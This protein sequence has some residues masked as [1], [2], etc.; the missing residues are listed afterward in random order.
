MERSTLV[1]PRIARRP[2]VRAR[3]AA[4]PVGVPHSTQ[5]TPMLTRLAHL[6]VRHRR[7]VI[8]AWLALTLVGVFAAGKVSTRWY[9]SFA[10]PGKPAY[11]ASQ[12]TLKAFGAGARSPSTV[13]F[14]TSGD[15]TRST[16]VEAA[17]Q[18]AA[19][20]MPGA[21]ATS[22]F[23]TGDLMYVSRDRHTA[24]MNVYPPG[25]TRLDLKSGAEQMRAAAARGLPPGIAVDVTGHDPLEEATS[26]GSSGGSVLLEA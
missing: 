25:P 6:T 3:A 14:H 18:R 5:E 9:Q 24:F 15:A 8:G 22:Y 12:R 17:M 11:E 16:A 1:G 19:D 26:H 10:I 21:R 20:A 23:S 7:A 13:V 2:I 4:N